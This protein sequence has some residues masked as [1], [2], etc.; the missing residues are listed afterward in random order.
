MDALDEARK[1]V[2]EARQQVDA[3]LDSGVETLSSVLKDGLRDAKALGEQQIGKAK[4]C[5]P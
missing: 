1:A 4:V 2:K 5:T 3:T